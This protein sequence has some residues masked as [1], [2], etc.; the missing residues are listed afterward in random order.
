MLLLGKD[1]PIAS[2]TQAMVLA[3]ILAAAGAVA[4]AGDLLERGQVLQR[5]VAGGMLAD[6]LEHVDHGHVAVLVAAR[7]DRAAVDEDRR[8]V[9]PQHRH[10]HAGQD[11]VA[12]GEADQRVIAVPAH[13]QLDRIGDHL[14]A[15]QRAFHA[16]VAH[17]DPVGDGD[18]V[19]PARRAA[20][21]LD[22]GAADVGLEIERGVARR[23]VVAGRGDGDE[24]AVDLLLGH[25]HRVVI[26]A[27]RRALG[28]DRNVAAGQAGLVESVR[29][30]R[31]P[32]SRDAFAGLHPPVKPHRPDSIRV[33]RKSRHA[34]QGADF[35]PTRTGC[36]W[37]AECPL[38]CHQAGSIAAPPRR[39]LAVSN[40]AKQVAPEPLIRTSQAR[41]LAQR[42]EHLGDHRAQ[43]DRRALPDRCARPARSRA[44]CRRQRAA[45]HARP[46]RR[47][48]ARSPAA[49]AG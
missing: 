37:L 43:R 40:S 35:A 1:N 12:P 9:E 5:A 46:S 36:G 11:L 34:A 16:L 7:Q 24:R 44:R 31:Y 32:S 29:H 25:P 18:G 17:R 48:P 19:E 4:G 33:E 47:T 38:I 39:V 13:R 49:R 6:R 2:P 15:D 21:L 20:A 42:G 30:R 8:H 41:R 3:V 26:G 14:A 28:A 27:V 45:I 10:H 23:A 22:A